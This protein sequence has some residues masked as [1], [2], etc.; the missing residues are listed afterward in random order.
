MGVEATLPGDDIARNF[1][2]LF[3]GVV[4]GTLS[5]AANKVAFHVGSKLASRGDRIAIALCAA[6]FIGL[7]AT[8][9]TI[10]LTGVGHDIVA[11]EQLRRPLVAMER[12]KDRLLS[13]GSQTSGIGSLASAASSDIDSLVSCEIRGGCISGRS[14]V[15]RQVSELRSIASRLR[16]FERTFEGSKRKRSSYAARLAKLAAD[17]EEQLGVGGASPKNR[18]ALL[19]I[20]S[21]ARA[22]LTD[23]EGETNGA[24][25]GAL[26]S[27]LRGFR[28]R[29]GVGRINLSARLRQHAD[30]IEE[31]LPTLGRSEIELPSFPGPVGITAAWGHLDKV[32]PYALLLF[33]LESIVIVLWIMLVRRLVAWREHLAQ[34]ESVEAAQSSHGARRHD[35]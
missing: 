10:G 32:W 35:E 26:V 31:A 11:A 12:A 18:A 2:V 8:V 28:S 34:L 22:V 13:S 30:R 27:E 14:G 33:G 24:A 29:N 3:V 6:W 23:L 5:F 25:I 21:Q 16:A 19:K 9:G 1:M 7:G 20:Y 4:A 15:G 17:Y